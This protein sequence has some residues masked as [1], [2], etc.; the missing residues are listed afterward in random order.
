MNDDAERALKH[1][2]F[3]NSSHFCEEKCETFSSKNLAIFDWETPKHNMGKFSMIQSM[4]GESN[5]PLK[6]IK[7]AQ[8]EKISDSKNFLENSKKYVMS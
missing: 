4:L 2:Y 3:L 5:I 1:S 6:P 7:F 8:K